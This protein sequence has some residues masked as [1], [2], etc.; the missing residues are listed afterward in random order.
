MLRWFSRHVLPPDGGAEDVG[1]PGGGG[2]AGRCVKMCSTSSSSGSS[3]ALAT[4][5]VCTTPVVTWS[6]IKLDTLSYAVSPTCHGA[7]GICEEPGAR[8]C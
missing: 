6:P 3:S 5:S 1:S 4:V 8:Q 7:V 2:H